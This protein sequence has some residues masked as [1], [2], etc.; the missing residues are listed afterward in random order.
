MP[1]PEPAS[2]LLVSFNNCHSF[3]QVDPS[4]PRCYHSCITVKLSKL[5]IRFLAT[6]R[7]ADV[8]RP[9]SRIAVGVSGGADSVALFRLLHKLRESLGITLLI[10]HF[11]HCL[12]GEESTADSEFVKSL[13]QAH[14]AEY[15]TDRADVA[16]FAKKNRLNLEDAARRL[17]YAFLE[18]IVSEG[19]ATNVAV[20]H[21]ADDQAETVLARILRGSG[22]SGLAS[23]YPTLGS[24]IR[25][26]LGFRR[27]ELRAYLRSLRQPWREDT[28]NT[29]ISRQR[30]QIRLQL[31]PILERDFSRSIVERLCTLARLA[32][33]ENEFWDALVEDRFIALTRQSGDSG[34]RSIVI[35]ISALLTPLSLTPAISNDSAASQS[36]KTVTERLIRRL[37]KGIRGD[38]RNLTAKH[39]DAIYQLATAGMSGHQLDNL[40]GVCVERI[41]DELAFSPRAVPDKGIRHSRVRSARTSYHYVVNVPAAGSAAVPV[42][43]L[44]TRLLLKVIDWPSMRRDTKRDDALDADL[45]P[46]TL[47]LRNWQPGDAYRPRGHSQKRKLKELFLSRRVPRDERTFW[48]VVEAGGRIVWSRGMPPA[49]DFCVSDGTRSGILIDEG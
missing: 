3:R 13:A 44:G 12:R 4:P 14:H 39:V 45:L 37:Y 34:T 25:P 15:F 1:D 6:L 29:D 48:P 24:V 49:A 40:P 35:P 19:R 46:T 38:A 7:R 2:R 20:A 9:G 41:F 10:L 33:E 43:E 5:E 30:A 22:P 21:T 28:S 11:D 31:L 42:P 36:T 26:L 16:S 23:I 18:R 8:I 32:R 17:R 27:D 47:T